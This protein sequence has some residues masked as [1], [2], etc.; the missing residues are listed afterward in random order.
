MLC[1][2]A[3]RCSHRVS[4]ANKADFMVVHSTCSEMHVLRLRRAHRPPP[5]YTRHTLAQKS[6]KHTLA[7]EPL[8]DVCAHSLTRTHP[9]PSPPIEQY[10][11]S[12]T[13]IRARRRSSTTTGRTGSAVILSGNGP[14]GSIAAPKNVSGSRRS[15]A[16][17]AA[18]FRYALIIC[19]QRVLSASRIR[20]DSFRSLKC[21]IFLSL[22]ND[23]HRHSSAPP[24][25]S[26]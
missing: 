19:G 18:Y 4:H 13:N 9:L 22:K 15:T 21:K 2:A 7:G 24:F 26:F 8:R 6:Y 1:C 5:P 11:K 25:G 12:I 20:S 17:F 14:F 3:T 10:I 23:F 16:G